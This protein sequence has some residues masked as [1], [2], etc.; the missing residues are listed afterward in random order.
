MKKVKHSQLHPEGGSLSF[1]ELHQFLTQTFNESFLLLCLQDQEQRHDAVHHTLYIC[2]R[3]AQR[4]K[5]IRRW[6]VSS[7]SSSDTY[8][9]WKKLYSFGTGFEIDDIYSNLWVYLD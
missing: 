8:T 4:G 9:V 7:N 6:K 3:D 1:S 5:A 2:K